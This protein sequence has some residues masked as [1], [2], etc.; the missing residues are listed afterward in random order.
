[1]HKIFLILLGTIVIAALLG[2]N[3]IH[4]QQL[5]R[6]GY[7]GTGVAK[8]LHKTIERA[9][10][11]KKRGLDIR[12]IYF[13]SGA[14]MAQAMVGGDLDIADSDV[15]A[16]LNAVSSGVLD[17]KLISVYV[18][19]FPFAFVVRNEIKSAEDLKG[20]RLAISRFATKTCASSKP[21]ARRAFPRWWPGNSMARCSELTM[22]R[23]SW[24]RDA[25]AF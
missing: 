2:S 5:V 13:T 9:G 4:A 22:C 15:P 24:N 20:K 1:M 21:L 16:M 17:G 25:A 23:R 19:R 18:N 3:S 6:V 7:S 11:W 10:L 8:N 12:L 14:T